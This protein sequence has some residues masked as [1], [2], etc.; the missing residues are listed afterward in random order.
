V[1]VRIQK[2]NGGVIEEGD[3]SLLPDGLKWMYFSAVANGTITGTTVNFIA[4]D[5]PG[6]SISKL[7]I[8]EAIPGFCFI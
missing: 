4:T 2:D 5:L 8:P 7:K 1:K 6:H 3:A